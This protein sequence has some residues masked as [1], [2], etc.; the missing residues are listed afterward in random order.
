MNTLAM[1]SSVVLVAAVVA[2]LAGASWAL[3]G[4]AGFIAMI[5]LLVSSFKSVFFE[6]PSSQQEVAE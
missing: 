6:E 2:K 4:L 3:V 1:V 5:A